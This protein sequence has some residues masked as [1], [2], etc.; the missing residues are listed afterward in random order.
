[1]MR[2]PVTPGEQGGRIRSPFSMLM[3]MRVG[4]FAAIALQSLEAQQPVVLV[5]GIFSNGSTWATTAQRLQQ[6]YNVTTTSPNLPSGETYENQAGSLIGQVGGLPANTIAFAHSNGGL[7]S[8][9]AN[10]NGRAWSGIGTIGTGHTGFPLAQSVLNFWVFEEARYIINS[11]LQ[12][13]AYYSRFYPDDWAWQ[14]AGRIGNWAASMG[15]TIPAAIASLGFNLAN[16]VL[17]EMV[18][19]SAFMDQ[20][21]DAPAN[22][23]REATA[24]ARRVSITS[25]VQTSYG[26]FFQA[27]VPDNYTHYA[28]YQY[29]AGAVFYSVGLYYDEFVDYNDP[30]WYDKQAD[31][32]LWFQASAAMFNFDQDWCYIIGAYDNYGQCT[33]NDGV[34]PT[35][36]MPYPGGTRNVDIVGPAH[37]Q[38]TR[39]GYA[40]IAQ[41]LVQ[42]FG[43]T[44]VS[45]DPFTSVTVS[46]PSRV[47]G[48]VG[49][50]W[51][52]TPSGGTA[53][54]TYSW[55]VE[56]DSQNTWTDNHLYYTNT[57]TQPSIFVRATATDAH[58]VVVSSN[59][60]KTNITLPGSC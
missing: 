37:L 38:E 32:Y 27:V 23:N 18:P 56:E 40:A 53:P 50:T 25:T 15:L 39:D 58:G 47:N 24:L 29:L 3:M 42:D 52:A 21:I 54:I 16:P 35:Y 6:N 36:R 17:P 8:R 1:M 48:C 33:Q 26:M 43:V 4:A 28:N 57:G 34:V 49:G 10:E 44:P 22:L 51:T 2:T 31:A 60:F 14:I 12:P 46:G 45:G 30:W 13:F 41:V 20:N 5:H 55:T 7:V 9:Q 19:G 59:S 11:V